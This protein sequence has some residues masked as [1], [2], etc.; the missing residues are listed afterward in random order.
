MRAIGYFTVH[1]TQIH[2]DTFPRRACP[3][4]QLPLPMSVSVAPNL[5]VREIQEP[6]F[7]TKHVTSPVSRYRWKVIRVV[8]D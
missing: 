5:R 7:S 2:R 4:H 8:W 1:R 3:G 6:K